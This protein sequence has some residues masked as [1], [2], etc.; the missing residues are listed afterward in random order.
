MSR[1]KKRST[2]PLEK[3]FISLNHLSVIEQN[4]LEKLILYDGYR[5]ISF[6]K[7]RGKSE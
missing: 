1:E 6:L 7:Y 5:M 4:Q 3:E 2:Y